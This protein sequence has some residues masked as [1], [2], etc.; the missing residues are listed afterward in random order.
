[1]ETQSGE[2]KWNFAGFVRVA[3][4]FRFSPSVFVYA[5]FG[6]NAGFPTTFW[7]CVT[8]GTHTHKYIWKEINTGGKWCMQ[9]YY[10]T[11]SIYVTDSKHQY[12]VLQEVSGNAFTLHIN[13]ISTHTNNIY[14]FWNKGDTVTYIGNW[15]MFY[16]SN[17]ILNSENRML[18]PH[19]ERRWRNIP[20][21]HLNIIPKTTFFS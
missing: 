1:M 21:L 7:I 13:R 20:T 14:V 11:A 17:V 2:R 10:L 5:L 9:R 18:S 4:S 12:N 16:A 19:R 15:C 3:N 6:Q 8:A